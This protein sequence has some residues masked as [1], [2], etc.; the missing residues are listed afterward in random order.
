MIPPCFCGCPLQRLDP[1]TSWPAEAREYLTA[2]D[3]A[4]AP[5]PQFAPSDATLA[6]VVHVMT[7]HDATDLDWAIEQMR[8]NKR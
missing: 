7:V 6:L 8:S 2:V 4:Y 5:T 3:S 1:G